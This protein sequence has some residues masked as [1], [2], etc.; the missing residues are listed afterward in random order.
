MSDEIAIAVV[1][2][3]EV[4]KA[5]NARMGEMTGTASG[6][7]VLIRTPE[8]E[9]DRRYKVIKP[10]IAIL[11]RAAWLFG[12]TFLGGMGADDAAAMVGITTEA[13][14]PSQA[15]YIALSAAAIGA[16][17]DAV[18]ILGELKNKYPLLSGGI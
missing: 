9:R 10:A 12:T 18:G 13:L 14:D 11:V 16:V 1:G 2:T 7:E 3:P 17:K 8:G 15:A 4:H 6:K 5:I